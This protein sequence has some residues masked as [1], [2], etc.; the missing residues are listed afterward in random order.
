MC[1]C[2][3]VCCDVSDNRERMCVFVC[4]CVSEEA[5]VCVCNCSATL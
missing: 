5:N 2:V 1:V 4:V 3:H